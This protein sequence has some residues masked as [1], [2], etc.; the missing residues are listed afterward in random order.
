MD[1]QAATKTCTKCGETKALGQFHR[2]AKSPGGFK[3]SCKACRLAYE[4]ARRKERG[5][6]IN[7][8]RR[9]RYADDPARVKKLNRQYYARNRGKVCE[10]ER[11][12]RLENPEKI[13]SQKA[14]Y[15]QEN[16]EVICQKNAE[17]RRANPDKVNTYSRTWKKRNPEKVKDSARRLYQSDPQRHAKRLAEWRLKNTDKVAAQRARQNERRRNDPGW[18]KANRQRTQRRRSLRAAATVKPFTAA[19]LAASYEAR[20]LA[21]CV[22]CGGPH[23]HDDH[24]I[25]LA[26]GGYHATWNLV[27][28]CAACNCSKGAKDVLAWLG[29]REVPPAVSAALSAHEDHQKE[30]A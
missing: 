15:F 16:K 13:R 10:R 5:A 30:I 29:D 23:D 14:E 22:Y 24:I 12:R 20:G 21:T 2:H 17:W 4:A 25:P 27:P 1:T 9:V 26:R 18:A 7:S 19:D 6:E 3:P 8:R 11:Q 28:A